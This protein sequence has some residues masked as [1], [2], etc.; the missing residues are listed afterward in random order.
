MT[1]DEQEFDLFD[2]QTY[3]S[4]VHSITVDRCR[5]ETCNA[6]V[7]RFFQHGKQVFVLSRLPK[8]EHYNRDFNWEVSKI[9]HGQPVTRICF[10]TMLDGIGHIMRV[11]D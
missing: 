4:V 1:Q 3:L 11:T 5:H 9:L 6:T 2:A 7:L 8:P 10:R